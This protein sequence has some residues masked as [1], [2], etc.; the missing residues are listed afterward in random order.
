MRPKLLTVDQ[1]RQ[2]L[3]VTEPMTD[4]GFTVGNA[5]RFVVNPGW[6][7]AAPAKD[8]HERVDAQLQLGVGRSAVTLPLSKRAL[9]EALH[10]CGIR[11]V[12]ALLMPAQLIETHLNFWFRDSIPLPVGGTGKSRSRNFKALV[13]DGTVIAVVNGVNTVHSN[14]RL[15]DQVL[16][17]IAARYGHS[18]VLLDY[19]FQ[20]TPQHTTMRFIVPDVQHAM[21]GTGVPDDTCSAG[22][23]VTNSQLGDKGTAVSGYLFRWVCTNGAV[24]RHNHKR[25]ALPSRQH[26]L[27]AGNPYDWARD[28]VDEVLGGLDGAFERIQQLAG[29]EVGGRLGDVLRILFNTYRVTAADREAILDRVTAHDGELSMYTLMGLITELANDAGPAQAD[30]LLSFGGELPHSDGRCG[31]CR[32]QPA[33]A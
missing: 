33:A 8:D 30:R 9:F 25:E 21:Q 3:A 16:A 14:L 20:H 13:L 22:V 17:G 4:Y 29:V 31:A 5:V 18:E 23:Q 12:H 7:H 2:R 27:L 1:A 32:R 10:F 11:A 26:A 28:A 24:D 6:Q 15:V 19:K